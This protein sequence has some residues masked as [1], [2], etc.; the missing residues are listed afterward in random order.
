MGRFNQQPYA[1]LEPTAGGLRYNASFADGMN[2]AFKAA[3]PSNQRK[4]V[5]GGDGRFSHWLIDPAAAPI[6][7]RIVKQFLGI[8]LAIPQVA[9]TIA[10]EEMRILRLIYIGST[11]QVGSESIARGYDG[12]SWDALLP[13]KVLRKW[14]CDELD[15]EPAKQPDKPV[16]P[17]KPKTHYAVLGLVRT[18]E[19]IDIKK[20]YRRLAMQWH[21]DV[22]REDGARE[23]FEKIQHAYNLLGDPNKRRAYD[24]GLILTEKSTPPERYNPV[25]VGKTLYNFHSMYGYRTPDRCGLILAK[26]RPAVAGFTV[27]QIMNW[28]PIVDS[29]GRTLV[30]SFDSVM[31]EVIQRWV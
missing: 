26:G 7:Q 15:D 9:P 19:E 8:D 6:V 29:Q 21:P 24:V 1:R 20:A 12:K 28:Q 30:S 13:E 11:K 14:F 4:P 25:D 5:M 23:M 10:A 2:D 3:V 31:K 22:C 18:A 27:E 16:E 17:F